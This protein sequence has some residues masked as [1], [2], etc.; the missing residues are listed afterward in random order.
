MGRTVTFSAQTSFGYVSVTGTVPNNYPS[1]YTFIASASISDGFGATLI[2]EMST[3]NELMFIVRLDLVDDATVGGRQFWVQATKL[4]FGNVSTLINETPL[5]YSEYLARCRRF[6]YQ[7]E[8]SGTWGFAHYPLGGS[9]LYFYIPASL[10]KN[11]NVTF[12]DFSVFDDGGTWYAPSS[13]GH[14]IGTPGGDVVFFT[15]SGGNYTNGR[16]YLIKGY[17]KVDTSMGA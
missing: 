5:T 4:E 8:S 7:N 1:A 2:I 13:G 9:Y 11:G 15:P 10:R 6:Y 3:H 17:V 12:Q 16:E 14:N